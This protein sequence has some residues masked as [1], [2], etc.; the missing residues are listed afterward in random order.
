MARINSTLPAPKQAIIVYQKT[1]EHLFNNTLLF[2]YVAV[3]K[4]AVDEGYDVI[5][6]DH[7]GEATLISDASHLRNYVNNISGIKYF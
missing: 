6:H 1:I 2:E 3:L 5:F 4:K 7:G